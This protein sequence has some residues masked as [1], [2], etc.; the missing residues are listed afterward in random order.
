MH[1]ARTQFY[2]IQIS[3][4]GFKF[5]IL[6]HFPYCNVRFQHTTYVVLEVADIMEDL[7]ATPQARA[8]PT[9]R[10]LR[11]Q[12]QGGG[13]L[14][15]PAAPRTPTNALNASMKLLDEALGSPIP[16]ADQY[17]T[18]DVTRMMEV[19]RPVDST[20]L[21][22][23]GDNT[24]ISTRADFTMA[25]DVTRP[26]LETSAMLGEENPGVAATENLFQVSSHPS[27]EKSNLSS[28]AGLPLNC[29]K[30]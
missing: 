24:M 19:T 25:A 14:A 29:V 20:R 12:S 21:A 2:E 4:S 7:L 13:A 27:C 26:S 5:F 15:R 8:G 28:P 18:E 1:K 30:R 16:S 22:M 11:R 17:L 6:G 10:L 23:R 9:S 3:Q